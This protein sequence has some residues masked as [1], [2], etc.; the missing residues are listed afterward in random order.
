MSAW[1]KRPIA[2][3]AYITIELIK[4]PKRETKRGTYPERLAIQVRTN[5]AFRG[6]ILENSRE[7]EALI[8][9]I[10]AIEQ[11]LKDIGKALDTISGA[12]LELELFE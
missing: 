7:I 9:L 5:D 4:L 10:K 12:P 6:L 1:E 8:E 11:K 3:N 2:K